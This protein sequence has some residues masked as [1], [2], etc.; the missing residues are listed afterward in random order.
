MDDPKTDTQAKPTQMQHKYLCAQ[1][2]RVHALSR[3]DTVRCV[4]LANFIC[5]L[6]GIP[7]IGL[8]VADFPRTTIA[9]L[10]LSRDDL[11]VLASDLDKELQKNQELFHV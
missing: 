4:E 2:G 6:K 7:A 5:S 8:P 1:C 11:A 3:R 9:S 10:G